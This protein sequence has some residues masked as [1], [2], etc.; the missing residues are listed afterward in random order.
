VC[1]CVCP[2]DAWFWYSPWADCILTWLGFESNNHSAHEG[3]VREKPY[4]EQR[5]CITCTL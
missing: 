1:M 3:A 2:Y 5:D 4:G